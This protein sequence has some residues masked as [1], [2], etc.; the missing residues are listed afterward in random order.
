M[1]SDK[2]TDLEDKLMIG[3]P[4]SL[5]FGQVRGWTALRFDECTAKLK[6]A[7]K[8]IDDA[9]VKVPR[10]D[11]AGEVKLK[12]GESPKIEKPKGVKDLIYTTDG[13]DP[14]QSDKATKVSEVSE[15]WSEIKDK[16]CVVIS[17]RAIDAAGNF[18]ELQQIKLVN[19]DREYD[20]DVK[21]G[22][23]ESEGHFK[24]PEDDYSL[25]LVLRSLVAEAEKRKVIDKKRAEQFRSVIV[26]LSDQRS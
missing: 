11:I 14:K 26:T 25:V 9:R 3:I 24:F 6:A 1:L 15:I 18:G 16:S 10:L 17:V 2:K 7:R 5:G 4:S 12:P 23:F 21:K 20:V 8:V 13:E 19:I 22:F